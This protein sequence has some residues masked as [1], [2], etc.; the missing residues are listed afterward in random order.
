MSIFLIAFSLNVST[1]SSQTHWQLLTNPSG[2]FGQGLPTPYFLNTQVGFIFS[3]SSYIVAGDTA[4]RMNRTT[5]GGFRWTYLEYFDSIGFR[6]RQVYFTSINHGY[7]AGSKGVYETFDTGSTWKRISKD[8]NT[9]CS[10]YAAGSSVYAFLFPVPHPDKMNGFFGTLIST[11]D[12]GATWHTIMQARGPSAPPLPIVPPYVFGNRDSLVFAENYDNQSFRLYYST[13]NGKSWNSNSF[14]ENNPCGLYCFPH[15]SKVEGTFITPTTEDDRYTIKETTDFGATWNTTLPNREMGSWLTGNNCV[16]YGSDANYWK[17]NIDT[18]LGPLRSLQGGEN[19]TFNTYP[20]GDGPTFV[21]IDDR[22][23]NPFGATDFAVSDWRN[24]SSVGGGA[25][26]Y[27]A[28]CSDELWKST[29]GGDGTLSASALA[30]KL[31]ISNDLVRGNPDT[32]YGGICD[33]AMMTVAFQNISCNYAQFLGMHFDELDSTEFTSVFKHHQLC[34][35]LSDTLLIRIYPHLSSP[36][37]DLNLHLQFINDEYEV[38]DTDFSFILKGSAS[39]GSRSVRFW[40]T[41]IINDS[42]NVTLSLPIYFHRSAVMNDVDMIM[43]YP[44]QSLKYIS[45]VTYKGNSLDMNG[46]RWPGR[47]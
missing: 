16:V 47:V 22:T 10:V 20:N 7:A 3:S 31:D 40:S 37:R 13:D 11:S 26:I 2:F 43:H 12:D 21:E 30:S 27:A 28:D 6:I 1:G 35:G 46:S 32:L 44:T 29:D 5:D 39:A 38:I 24:I 42:L 19:W 41:R 8:G 18:L 34:D 45:G 33:T 23:T 25:V 9:Y 36:L 14:A 4:S 17:S 15:C